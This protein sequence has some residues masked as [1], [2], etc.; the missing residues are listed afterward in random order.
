[1]ELDQVAGAARV[2]VGAGQVLVRVGQVAVVVV[3][4]LGLG[5]VRAHVELDVEMA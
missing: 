3:L 5:G 4:P 1:M 2:V